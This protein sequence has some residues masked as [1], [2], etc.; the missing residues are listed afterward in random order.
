MLPNDISNSDYTASNDLRIKNRRAYERKPSWLKTINLSQYSRSSYA[1]CS[2]YFS[3]LP[4]S[5]KLLQRT[6]AS[7]T[8]VPE[9]RFTWRN[10]LM[11][12]A[13]I[14]SVSP[15]TR[16]PTADTATSHCPFRLRS[17][18]RC[19]NF[20][21]KK[22]ASPVAKKMSSEEFQIGGIKPEERIKIF[23]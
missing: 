16:R 10:G 12:N 4:S 7:A 23:A 17:P 2:S 21:E 14:I 6:A 8:H 18:V 5:Y 19:S 22:T 9:H 15:A 1:R 13:R 20:R 3:T 11:E